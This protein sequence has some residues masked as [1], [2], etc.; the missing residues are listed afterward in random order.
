MNPVAEVRPTTQAPVSIGR[1]TTIDYA[2]DEFRESS[3]RLLAAACA[4]GPLCRVL[5]HDVPGLLRFSDVDAVLRD[6]V[7]FSSRTGLIE[8]PS[9][10]GRLTVLIGDDPPLHTR[11]RALLGQSFTAGRVSE[12]M[13]PRV[14]AIA[15]D[16]VQRIL[17]GGREFDLVTDLAV[18]LPVTVIAELLGVDAS[19][20]DDFKRWSDE[21]TGGILVVS[22]PEGPAKDARMAVFHQS[23]RDLEAYL[24]HSIAEKSKH[25]GNDFLSFMVQASGGAEKLSSEEVLGLAKLLLVAGNETTTKL[26]GLMMNQ[27][28]S[29][30]TSLREVNET[31]G[32]IPN[33][34]EETLRIEG[35]VY[36]RLRRTTK[37][38]TVAGLDVPA[39]ALVDCLIGA[40]NLDARVFP[41]PTRFDIRRRMARHFGFGTGLHQCL[42]APL[43]RLETRVVFEELFEHV[44]NIDLAGPARRG[45]ISSFRGFESMPLRYVVRKRSVPAGATRAIAQVAVAARIAKQSDEELGLLKRE[46]EIV[47]V[48]RV[49]D[50]AENIKMFR[51]V[52]PSGGLLTRFTAGSHIV[53]HMRDGNTV[54]RNPY[55]LLN[56]E[57]GNGQTYII[58]VALDA[59]GR[60]GSR[61]MH[62]KVSAGMDL[63]VS[64][65]ANNFPL[66]ANATKHLL[67][68]GGIGIT[69]IFAQRLE[70]R[71]RRQLC[72][73][74]YTFRSAASAAFVDLLEIE[75]DPNI[76]FYDNSLGRRLDVP[77]LLRAQPEGTAVYVCGPE[78]LM[79]E[80]IEVAFRLGWPEG[81]VHYERFGAPRPKNEAAFTVVC[82]RSRK[83]LTVG[84]DETLLEALEREGITVPYA[85]RSGSC[86]ACELPV[87]EGECEHRDSVFSEQERADG[88]KILACVSRAKKR[89]VLAI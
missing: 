4:S 66:A 74:H 77:T 84:G 56:C 3:V 11:L 52:H 5:P 68:A 72:E 14:V 85:C 79:D 36:N 81:Q 87:V 55:S 6:P 44:T 37:P 89:L 23:L 16:L 67:I 25:P 50:V 18:P 1:L 63:T 78:R 33:A 43:A 10:I 49:R 28:L 7:T 65:P 71:G 83:E 17:D 64:V 53:I 20:M 69:P 9:G 60:G 75:S 47:R 35:P 62:E 12:T 21:I 31:P 41:D 38:C 76:H 15:R 82:E 34:V 80:V 48:A 46:K 54:Y 70:I 2:S 57:W 8:P 27:L 51:F 59:Q 45:R 86:G 24:A 29:N 73:L 61:Y 58:A 13:E 30:P 88:K 42:G 22:M 19:D 32:L 26:I 40:A 39:G